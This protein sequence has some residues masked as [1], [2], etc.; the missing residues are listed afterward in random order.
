MSPSPDRPPLRTHAG[1]HTKGA[2]GCHVRANMPVGLRARAQS[3]PYPIRI[4]RMG[5]SP[6]SVLGLMRTIS[7]AQLEVKRQKGDTT[8]PCAR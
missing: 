8:D 5:D 1:T 6:L 2:G 7:S 4:T 3:S